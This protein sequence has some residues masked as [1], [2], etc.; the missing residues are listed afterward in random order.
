MVIARVVCVQ[1]ISAPVPSM[2]TLCRFLKVRWESFEAGATRCL[3]IGIFI[4][5]SPAATALSMKDCRSKLVPAEFSACRGIKI[6]GRQRHW[7]KKQP[8]MA[9]EILFAKVKSIKWETRISGIRLPYIPMNLL[10]LPDQCQHVVDQANV[11]RRNLGL[12]GS[13]PASKDQSL[14]ALF[15][16]EAKKHERV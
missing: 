16:L 7:I 15:V 2:T 6:N 5:V 11:I 8:L 12:A 4:W 9:I 14:D 10:L 13:L 1:I 3:P